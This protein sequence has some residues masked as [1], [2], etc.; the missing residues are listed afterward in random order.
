[1]IEKIKIEIDL[2]KDSLNII[3]FYINFIHSNCKNEIRNLLL[4]EKK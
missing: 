2:L 4:E 1:M 3:V